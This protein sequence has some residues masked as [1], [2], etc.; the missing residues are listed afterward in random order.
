MN[1]SPEA[2][3]ELKRRLREAEDTIRAIRE[4][5][6]DALVV[7]L[8]DRAE[9]FPIGGDVDAFR[10]FLDA[11]QPGAAAIDGEGRLLYANAVFAEMMG[12]PL[13]TLRGR[14]V[15]SLF[16][17][18]AAGVIAEVISGSEGCR[19]GLP[20]RLQAGSAPRDVLAA[21][22]PLSLGT[23]RGVALTLTDLTERLRAE[24]LERSGRVAAAIIASAAEAVMVCDLAGIVTHANNAARA[25]FAGAPEGQP[26]AQIVPL[27]FVA[28]DAPCNMAEMLRRAM[29]GE[30]VQG[31]EARAPQGATAVD[32]L[33]SAAPLIVG[34]AE[35]AGCVVTLVDIGERKALERQQL[36][37]MQELDHRVKNILA[38]VLSI[39]RRTQ[40]HTDGIEQFMG[41]FTGRIHALSATHNLLAEK[42]WAELTVGEIL[43]A[44]LAPFGL[45]GSGRVVLHDLDRAISPRAAVSLGMLFHELTTNA[46]K[47]GALR[48]DSGVI[49][50][51]ARRVAA[52]GGLVIVWKEQVS[53]AVTT[54]VKQ[55][56]GTA[57][58]AQ[59]MQHAPGGGTEVAFE[60]DGLRCTIAVP[61]EDTL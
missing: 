10:A 41:A 19:S 35:V 58:I 31:L 56:F 46:A 53:H 32:L 15:A 38:V 42:S 20:L 24:Q 21:A 30:A 12:A 45:E 43:G 55:G 40:R 14:V 52:P 17:E 33:V 3:A 61:G 22:A 48:G 57:V 4:G 13:E 50:V 26:L 27:E 59:S 8:E 54:P 39:S 11:M 9:V 37:L 18:A 28:P 23:T 51:S 2:I 34:E 1:I 7:G 25:V 36:L 29:A 16:D 44:E 6:V 49:T 5:E 47:Y 60:T